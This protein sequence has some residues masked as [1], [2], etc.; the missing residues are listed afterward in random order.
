STAVLL[1]LKLESA[2]AS[3]RSGTRFRRIFDHPSALTYLRALRSTQISF[4]CFRA[5]ESQ[6]GRLKYSRSPELLV[7]RAKSQKGSDRGGRAK[8]RS[9]RETASGPKSPER[10]K[11]WQRG[12]RK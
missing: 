10:P 5:F 8:A 1:P 3:Q 6:F 4:C 9:V 12:A 7:P 11:C 2:L